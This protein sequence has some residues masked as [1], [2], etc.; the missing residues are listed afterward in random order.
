MPNFVIDGNMDVLATP[1]FVSY[2]PIIFVL[3]L[4]S[5]KVVETFQT[6]QNVRNGHIY[7]SIIN[8]H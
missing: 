6:H 2:A 5:K 8:S 3:I 4:G 7:M 1:F